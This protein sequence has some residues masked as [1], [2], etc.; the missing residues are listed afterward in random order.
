MQ[1]KTFGTFTTE[2][3]T[4]PTTFSCP[5]P[6]DC[7]PNNPKALYTYTDD[8][9]GHI[10]IQIPNRLALYDLIKDL[11]NAISEEIEGYAQGENP[12][13]PLDDATCDIHTAIDILSELK[14]FDEF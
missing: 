11:N 3:G 9:E 2:K 1:N 5:D 14:A 10:E 12:T 4:Y 6:M 8:E 13:A 7:A